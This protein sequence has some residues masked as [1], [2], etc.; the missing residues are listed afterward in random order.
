MNAKPSAPILE[1]MA[2]K[3][4]GL[5][6]FL[7]FTDR[8]LQQLQQKNLADIPHLLEERNRLIQQMDRMDRQTGLDR[9]DPS[10]A[11]G[12]M[13]GPL[14]KRWDS[15]VQELRD[16]LQ[17]AADQDHQCFLEAQALK[18]SIRDELV[19]FRKNSRVAR[20]YAGRRSLQ[21]RFMDCRE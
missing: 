4:S 7:A 17:Q 1:D 11:Q 8:L 21:P 10:L 2:G 13:Y 15:M 18:E 5:K 20:F 16:L 12:N 19:Q 6:E 9:F 3:I 14:Q